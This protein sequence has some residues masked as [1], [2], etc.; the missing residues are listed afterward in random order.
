MASPYYSTLGRV[1]D[2][3]GDAPEA[4]D[5]NP[6]AQGDILLHRVTG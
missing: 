5:G 1:R 4:A 3:L 6:V 2:N